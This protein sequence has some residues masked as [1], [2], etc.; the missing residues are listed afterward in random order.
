MCCHSVSVCVSVACQYYIK[1]VKRRM[2][3]TV[4]LNIPGI[5]VLVFCLFGLFAAFHTIDHNILIAHFS[6]WFGVHGSIFDWFR[7]HL[8]SWCFRVKCQNEFSSLHTSSCDVLK[9]LFLVLYSSLSSTPLISVLL[10]PPFLWTIT[11]SKIWH[12]HRIGIVFEMLVMTE[13]YCGS[14]WVY[15]IY[16]ISSFWLHVGLQLSAMLQL[17][18]LAL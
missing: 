10:S 15:T 7:F 1:T 5:L 8:S 16:L 17:R 14:D 9:V 3:Q 11:V 6:S 4:P 18:I 13:G 12:Q 2:M